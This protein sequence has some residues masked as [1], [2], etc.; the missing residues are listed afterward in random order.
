[1]SGFKW[2]SLSNAT[3]DDLER[4]KVAKGGWLKGLGLGFGRAQY[5][6]SQLKTLAP[7]G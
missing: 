3:S 4:A 2:M 5:D 7:N 6:D 1:M